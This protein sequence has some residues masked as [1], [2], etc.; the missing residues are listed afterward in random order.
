V[1][2]L[3]IWV[4]SQTILVQFPE[5]ISSGPHIRDLTSSYG[6][7][8]YPHTYGTH[9]HTHTHT[10][11]QRERQR[12]IERQR[13]NWFLMSQC[14]NKF[15]WNGKQYCTYTRER[16]GFLPTTGISGNTARSK[17]KKAQL[18]KVIYNQEKKYLFRQIW[19]RKLFL[20]SHTVHG[21]NWKKNYAEFIW[22]L[23]LY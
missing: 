22:I 3:E 21:W 11:T 2:G 8:G 10:H 4:S 18:R 19:Y 6:L 13:Q 7:H 15:Y 5:P 20:A 12:Q 1:L 9:T 17:E 23:T 14:Q 16:F